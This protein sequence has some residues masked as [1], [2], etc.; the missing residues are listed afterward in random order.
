MSRVAILL[1]Q[2]VVVSLKCCP[3][4]LSDCISVN[5]IRERKLSTVQR[6]VSFSNSEDSIL[7]ASEDLKS[8]I[9]SRVF[10]MFCIT[11]AVPVMP[12]LKKVHLYHSYI[13]EQLSI[14]SNTIHQMPHC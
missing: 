13:I 3:V 4:R 5:T 14:A 10:P 6:L 9:S 2:E 1:K 8:M 7:R 11:R 12:L